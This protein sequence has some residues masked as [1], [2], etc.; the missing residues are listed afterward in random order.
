MNHRMKNLWFVLKMVE[1]VVEINNYKMRVDFQCVCCCFCCCCFFTCCLKFLIA[2]GGPLSQKAAMFG[3][4][5]YVDPLMLHTEPQ[6]SF[7]L[8]GTDSITISPH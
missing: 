5:R 4:A 2:L 3:V 1:G 7:Y 8:L 6:L